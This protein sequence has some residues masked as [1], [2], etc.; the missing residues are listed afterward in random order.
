M[1]IRLSPQLSV[2]FL[3]VP[4]APSYGYRFGL[5]QFG[6]STWNIPVQRDSINTLFPKGTKIKS[7][8]VIKPAAW[9]GW[10]AHGEPAALQHPFWGCQ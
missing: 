6:S 10:G 5:L 1:K 3:S 2:A 7:H 9:M 8:R 4:L